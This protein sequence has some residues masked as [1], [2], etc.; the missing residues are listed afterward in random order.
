MMLL[1]L[2]HLGH[3]YF[4]PLYG[5]PVLIVLWSAIATTRSERRAAREEDERSKD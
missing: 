5:L 4:W 3:W 1:P 2:A